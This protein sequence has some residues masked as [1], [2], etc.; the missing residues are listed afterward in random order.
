MV[1]MVYERKVL[2]YSVNNDHFLSAMIVN[3][4][5]YSDSAAIR[6]GKVGGNS[7]ARI[8]EII[9]SS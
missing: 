3:E 6:I 1:S 7:Y 8:E 4:G 5:G 2:L 9:P